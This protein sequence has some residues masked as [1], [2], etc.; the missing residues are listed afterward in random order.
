MIVRGPHV[1]GN[2]KARGNGNQRL[3]QLGG[4]DWRDKTRSRW[5][6]VLAQGFRFRRDANDNCEGIGQCITQ[7]THGSF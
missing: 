4:D 6:R 2:V 1:K 3:G 7:S 5:R